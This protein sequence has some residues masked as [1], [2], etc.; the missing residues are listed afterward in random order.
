MQ[1]KINR[2]KA[3]I[4]LIVICFSFLS[5]NAQTV[6]G[7]SNDTLTFCFL[8]D[9]QEPLFI[10]R[11]YLDYNHNAWARHLIFERITRL[12][13]EAVFHLGDFTGLGFMSDGWGETEDFV[14]NL[15]HHGTDF[16]PI[17]GNHEYIM[18]PEKSI[19]NFK[20]IFQ[21]TNLTGY[22]KRYNNLAVLL[23]NSNFANLKQS[24]INKQTSW[25]RDKINEL[26]ADTTIDFIIVGTH[27]SPYT[28][29]KVVLPATEDVSKGYFNNYLNP[30]Y[31]SK[32]CRLFIT[33]HT[34]AF[35]HFQVKGKDFLVI[36]G[37]GG[38]QQP[39]FTGRQEKYH[40]LYSTSLEKRM[41]HFIT[42][43][44]FDKTLTIDL[45]MVNDNFTDF[46]I[47]PQ[48]KFTKD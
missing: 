7:N 33:G 12:A 1:N 40:D 46:N 16:N 3:F 28:N 44:T 35:E 17:P 8:S 45:N 37:G 39:V 21:N 31:N 30:F 32:K 36:G 38:L 15:T 5:L 43:R 6:P 19:Y 47:I 14:N 9:S 24:E 4:L 18:F 25:Y 11:L 29:S 13:P 2:I 22:S 26:E 10:E 48:F 23:F 42:I 20:R 34:H 27:H 41:F